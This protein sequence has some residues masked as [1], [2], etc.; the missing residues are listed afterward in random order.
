MSYEEEE[1][2]QTLS[3]HT[4]TERSDAED[5]HH[6]SSSS[7]G[8]GMDFHPLLS[9]PNVE[10]EE[11]YKES[12]TSQWPLAP[13]FLKVMC[14]VRDEESGSELHVTAMDGLPLC[15]SELYCSSHNYVLPHSQALF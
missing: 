5:V 6:G 9:P 13:L 2:G 3:T 14:S 1:E 12:S 15:L 10:V 7:D 8:F 11:G 4:P